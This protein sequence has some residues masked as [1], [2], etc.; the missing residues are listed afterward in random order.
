MTARMNRPNHLCLMA[1]SALLIAPRA[2]AE[3]VHTIRQSG[4]PANRADIVILGDGYTADGLSRYAADAETLTAALF[5]QEPFRT[6][7]GY[8][9]VHR[10]EV[11]SA[12]SGSDHP[13]SEVSRDTAL[14]STYDCAGITRLICVDSGVVNDI[15]METLEPDSRDIIIVLVNDPEYGGS[16]G[17]IA[18]GSVHSAIPEIMLHELGH[19]LGLLADEYVDDFFCKMSGEPLGGNAT[20]ETDRARIKWRHWIDDTTALPSQIE[21]PGVPGLYAGAVYCSQ[22]KYRPTYDS[23]MRSLDRPF[24]QVNTEALTKHFYDHVSPIDEVTRELVRNG[25]SFAE[26]LTVRTPR[27]LTHRLQVRWWIDGRLTSTAPSITLQAGPLKTGLHRVTVMVSDPTPFVRHDPDRALVE[28]RS[29]DVFVGSSRVREV[30]PSSADAYV[31][32]GKW[33]RTNFSSAP[34]LS[35]KLGT[36]ADNTRESYLK[37]DISRVRAGDRIVLRLYGGLSAATGEPVRTGVHA[38]S[39]TSWHDTTVTWDTRPTTG[40]L[41][42]TVMTKKV[43]AKWVEADVTAFVQ[44]LRA[45]G[46]DVASFALRNAVRTTPYAM[47]NSTRATRNRPELMIVHRQ[48]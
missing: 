4:D 38:V 35:S 10:V 2:G 22:G 15:L 8:F 20:M 27:P 25:N 11:V 24:E 42:A 23:K 39:D 17:A 19:T 34:T 45:A 26:V 37:F 6:Y 46:H 31:R 12:E 3:P 1:L 33:G 41:L 43:T 16:G 21:E 9:N 5:A 47:F 29:W 40:A 36:L 13:A 30:V 14:H 7:R 48:K 18:V 44:S 28:S 32:G